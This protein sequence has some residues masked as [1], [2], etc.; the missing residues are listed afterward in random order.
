MGKR[1]RF[2]IFT[3]DDDERATVEQGV[4]NSENVRKNVLL[5]FSPNS[6]STKTEPK[7]LCTSAC[8]LQ[9]YVIR[10]RF[11]CYCYSHSRVCSTVSFLNYIRYFYNKTFCHLIYFISIYNS[12]LVTFIFPYISH[13]IKTFKVHKKSQNKNQFKW[14]QKGS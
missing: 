9:Y 5:N 2:G 8:F 6:T 1:F 11:F 14:K 10:F 7:Y 13:V 12:I 3:N 4:A